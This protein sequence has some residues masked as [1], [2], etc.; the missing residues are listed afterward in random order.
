MS[1]LRLVCPFQIRA[2]K[3]ILQ[4]EIV[5]G[6][7]IVPVLEVHRQLGSEK[8]ALDWDD[9]LTLE[10]MVVQSKETCQLHLL[11]WLIL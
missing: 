9:I 4:Q 3:K 8:N 5:L 2:F 6:K 10:A 7:G 11:F 1:F